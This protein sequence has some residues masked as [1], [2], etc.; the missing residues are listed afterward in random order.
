MGSLFVFRWAPALQA[1][2]VK[3]VALDLFGV[4]INGGI[5]ANLLT[6]LG[7]TPP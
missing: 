1:M 4:R 3:L 2:P 7:D 6:I 5:R